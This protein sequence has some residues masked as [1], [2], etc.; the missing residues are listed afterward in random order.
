MR[1]ET[2]SELN[3]LIDSYEERLKK[4][5]N[6]TAEATRQREAFLLDFRR[7]RTD[8]I[9]PLMEEIGN[10]IKARGYTYEISETED[11][12]TIVIDVPLRQRHYM[13]SFLA[14]RDRQ[15]VVSHPSNLPGN[16]QLESREFS[17]NEIIRKTVE[18]EVLRFLKRA[19]EFAAA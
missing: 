15:K 10:G 17:L 2:K 6:Q 11:P 13:H 8:T 16:L 5:T 9:R 18:R 4:E 12:L 19:F 14:A 1:K 7:I 3:A